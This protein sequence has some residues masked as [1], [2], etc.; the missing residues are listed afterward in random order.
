MTLCSKHYGITYN[1][2]CE[3]IQ[4]TKITLTNIASVDKLWDI[5]TKGQSGFI[6]QR[7]QKM[8]MG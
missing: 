3:Q 7:L 4:T 1:W 6:F 5:F 2:F 8:F